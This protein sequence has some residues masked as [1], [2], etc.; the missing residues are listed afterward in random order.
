[1]GELLLNQEQDILLKSVGMFCQDF[2]V[3]FKIEYGANFFL[4]P[5]EQK[6]GLSKKSFWDYP[7]GNVNMGTHIQRVA[8]C[9]SVRNTC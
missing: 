1:M 4:H 2:R 6:F 7:M 5:E 3:S 9:A 8:T